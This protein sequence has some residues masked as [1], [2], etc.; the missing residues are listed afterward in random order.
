MDSLFFRGSVNFNSRLSREKRREEKEREEKDWSA[1]RFR[2]D[3]S[4]GEGRETAEGGGG[5]AMA[6]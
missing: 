6:R 1:G 4:R 3:W 2:D 5:E